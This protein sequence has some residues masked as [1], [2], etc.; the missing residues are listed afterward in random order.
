MNIY[1]KCNLCQRNCLINRYKT[2]GYCGES[3]KIKIAKAI[4]TY[5]E[6]PCISN[7]NGSGT[8]FFSGCNLKC[9]YCQNQKISQN[10]FGVFIT[11]KRLAQIMLELQNKGAININLVTPTPYIPSIKKALIQAKKK[12]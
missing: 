4:L 8:I 11:I 12:G 7:K 1:K 6:E 3:N 5:Y 9:I 2:K 10:N